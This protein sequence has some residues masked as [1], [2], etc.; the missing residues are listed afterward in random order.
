MDA[1]IHT[2][3]PRWIATSIDVRRGMG[4]MDAQIHRA[5]ARAASRAGPTGLADLDGSKVTNAAAGGRRPTTAKSPTL[6]PQQQQRANRCGRGGGADSS[7]VTYA[8]VRCPGG[9]GVRRGTADSERRGRSAGD[10][11]SA[12]SYSWG[13]DASAG[14]SLISA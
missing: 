13:R 6:L 7:K 14:T 1:Q 5:D 3:F 2:R 11:A 9:R 12:P 4:A 8:V 10:G